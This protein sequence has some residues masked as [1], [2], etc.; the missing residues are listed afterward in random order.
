MRRPAPLFACFALSCLAAACGDVPASGPGTATPPAASGPTAGID[1][2]AKVIAHSTPTVTFDVVEPAADT[3]SSG[4]AGSVGAAQAAADD[5]VTQL[6][7]E[8]LQGLAQG[9]VDALATQ[10]DDLAASAQG[11]VDQLTQ[12]AHDALGNQLDGQFGGLFGGG[13]PAAEVD[14]I[15]VSTA[16]DGS[17]IVEGIEIP[18][19][20][21]AQAAAEAEVN[22]ANADTLLQQLLAEIEAELADDDG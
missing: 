15:A 7:G 22:D 13:T 19:T 6:P 21:A 17:V 12:Q 14:D 1:P 18:S 8:E 5:L 2:A 11:Q 20:A 10:A 4:L 16:E 9:H 3:S